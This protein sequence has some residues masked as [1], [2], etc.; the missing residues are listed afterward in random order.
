MKLACLPARFGGTYDYFSLILC[1]REREN[2]RGLFF[3][4]VE[5]VEV[6]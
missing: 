5:M 6:P 4:P 3:L 2:V 1:K